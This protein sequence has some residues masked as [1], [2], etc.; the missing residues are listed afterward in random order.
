M[1]DGRKESVWSLVVLVKFVV[2]VIDWIGFLFDIE[3]FVSLFLYGIGI[4]EMVN[5]FG[6]IYCMFYFYEEKNLIVV[7]CNGFMCVYDCK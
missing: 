5:V 3:L 7:S 4:V 2:K 6:V 1:L